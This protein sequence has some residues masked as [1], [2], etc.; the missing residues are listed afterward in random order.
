[1]RGIETQRVDA[2]RSLLADVKT[3]SDGLGAT[4]SLLQEVMKGLSS[5]SVPIL[6]RPNTFQSSA[7]IS[8]IMQAIPLQAPSPATNEYEITQLDRL[9]AVEQLYGAVDTDTAEILAAFPLAFTSGA[10]CDDFIEVVRVKR[11]VNLKIRDNLVPSLTGGGL[12]AAGVH[13]SSILQHVIS[14]STLH[15]LTKRLRQGGKELESIRNAVKPVIDTMTGRGKLTFA[16]KSITV[17]GPRWELARILFSQ[18]SDGVPESELEWRNGKLYF[19]HVL[20]RRHSQGDPIVAWPL[21]PEEVRLASYSRVLGWEVNAR[22]IDDDQTH[23]W[24]DFG[25]TLVDEPS[26]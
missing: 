25:K 21:H 24:I 11:D 19:T 9:L 6:W 16:G 15:S 20:S 4:H 1:M 26:A 14:F 10:A 12:H 22:L 18:L 8:A 23:I 13:I 7:H 17:G 3:A 2:V 5:S